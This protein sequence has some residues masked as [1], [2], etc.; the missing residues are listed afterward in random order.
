MIEL[1]TETWPRV[2]EVPATTWEPLAATAPPFL[3]HP[4]LSAL[5]ESGCVGSETGWEPTVITGHHDDRVVGA[6]AMYVKTHSMGEFVYDWSFAD[7]ARQY[8]IRYYPKAVITA[9]FSPIP[10]AKLLLED[11]SAEHAD[12]IREALLREAI[13]VAQAAGCESVH[14]LFCTEA[15]LAVARK[16]GFFGR[17]GTQLHWQNER[18]DDFDAFLGRFKAKRRKEIRRERRAITDSGLVI[19]A[20]SGD[21]IEDALCPAMYRFYRNTVTRFMYGRLY[22]NPAFFELLWDRMRD[23][24]QLTVARSK[25]QPV[26]GTLNFQRNGRRHGRYWGTDVDVRH[27]HFELTSYAAIEDCIRQNISAFEAGAGDYV[28]KLTRGFLPVVTQSAH[29]Y[30]H[31]DFHRLVEAYCGREAQAIREAIAQRYESPF[32]R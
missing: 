32:I 25:H 19:E 14:L 6:C 28:H 16:L 27:L 15:E 18:Y 22:L 9:P 12:A 5:E 10:S 4:F 20:L 17:L 11:A 21:A 13:A 29:L 7:A 2:G 30:F 1:K 26:A 8:G 23:R 24:L 3:E 31:N